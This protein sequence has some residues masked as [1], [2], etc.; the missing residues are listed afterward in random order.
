MAFGS[1]LRENTFSVDNDI[2]DA[3]RPD[4]QPPRGNIHFDLAHVQDFVRQTDGEGRIASSTAVFNSHFKQRVL[5]TNHLCKI[6]LLKP[7]FEPLSSFFNSKEY[8]ALNLL[9]VTRQINRHPHTN[10]VV[11][12]RAGHYH[13]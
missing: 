12:K 11:D 9:I 4:D 3:V 10:Q 1:L 5:H 7:S 2:K 6:I 8:I 13:R